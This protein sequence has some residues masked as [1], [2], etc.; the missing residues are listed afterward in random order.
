MRCMCLDD[1]TGVCCATCKYGVCWG[2]TYPNM[3]NC[4]RH[5][6]TR[7]PDDEVMWAE[8]RWPQVHRSDICG[9]YEPV[10]AKGDG[11]IAM[12]HTRGDSVLTP[13]PL[14]AERTE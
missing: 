14:C 4:H 7:K 10:P 12:N 11:G 5:A 9:D 2:C 8:G 3:I 1:A 6:P 13:C